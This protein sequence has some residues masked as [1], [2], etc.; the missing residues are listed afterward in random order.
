VGNVPLV[1]VVGVL[2][3]IIVEEVVGLALVDVLV[4]PGS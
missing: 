3:G 2:V 4:V 1:V